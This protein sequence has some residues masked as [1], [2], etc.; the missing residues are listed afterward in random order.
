MSPRSLVLWG[1]FIGMMFTP[2]SG[3][4]QA[5]AQ[6]WS[7][8][9]TPWGAPNFQGVW[10]FGV[11]TPLERPAEFGDRAFLTDEELAERAR[12]TEQFRIDH[13]T[14]VPA[15]EA[16]PSGLEKFGGNYNRFWTDP[17]R[18]AGQTSL[19]VEPADGRIPA[20][21]REA[22][23]WHADLERIR[24][25]VSNDA[26]TPG[27]F[28]DDLGRRGL[29]TRC[30]LGMN[31]GPPMAPNSYNENVQILQTPDY[32]VLLNEMVHSAR[33]VPLDT[34]PHLPQG[35]RQLKGDS[36]GHW[37]GDTLIIT[38]TNFTDQVFDVPGGVRPLGTGMILV[39]RFTRTA[40]D[41]LLYQ[42]T[43]DDPIWYTKPWTAQ[44][45]MLR[46]EEPTFEYACHEGNQSMVNILAGAK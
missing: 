46:N 23:K 3:V 6:N 37:E 15:T 43:L 33:I 5:Q 36:R 18:T 30:I 28:V 40:D 9:R 44:I 42:F 27:G 32:V 10:N 21:T 19:I 26:P 8:P 39:E 1:V 38:T 41:V 34:R 31:S 45:P 25:G 16:G 12:A 13:D 20:L 4:L 24:R 2:S 17:K 11:D 22:Q 35:I 14:H 7:L 29:F